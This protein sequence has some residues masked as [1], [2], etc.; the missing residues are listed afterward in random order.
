MCAVSVIPIRPSDTR[1]SQDSRHIDDP[2][3]LESLAQN[4]EEFFRFDGSPDARQLRVPFR[5]SEAIKKARRTPSLWRGIGVMATRI[6]G[7]GVDIVPRFPGATMTPE[8]ES[9][10]DLVELFIELS[11]ANCGGYTELRRLK[12]LDFYT[13]GNGAWRL[14]RNR[15]GAVAS[16]EHLPTISFRLYAPE[17]HVVR[18][19]IFLPRAGKVI[20]VER[21]RLFYTAR[22]YQ[23]G[24][25]RWYKQLGHPR[26]LRSTDGVQ[27][28]TGGGDFRDLEAQEF[29]LWRHLRPGEHHY[30]VPPWW[31]LDDETEAEAGVG[32]VLR[33][34]TKNGLM[35][36]LLVLLSNGEWTPATRAEIDRHLTEHSRGIERAFNVILG[37]AEAREVISD[38]DAA[39]QGANTVNV[40]DLSSKFSLDTMVSQMGAL[41]AHNRAYAFGIHPISMGLSSDYTRA[42][43]GA[44]K[45]MDEESIFIPARLTDDRTVNSRILPAMGVTHWVVRTR[46]APTQEAAEQAGAAAPFLAQGVLTLNQMLEWVGSIRGVQYEPIEE[47]WADVPVAALN[48]VMSGRQT[49]EDAQQDEGAVQRSAALGDAFRQRVTR[50]A[51]RFLDRLASTVED[52]DPG[53]LDR[54]AE[55]A[56]DVMRSAGLTPPG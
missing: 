24:V 8:Q 34:W 38:D 54:V 3:Q 12:D 32:R 45:A 41:A 51:D 2:V 16:A 26:P 21:P 6:G 44:A 47:E 28:K 40:V 35:S 11:G 53:F 49:P 52:S 42:T 37:E 20:E 46:N 39:K 30:G 36:T 13:V 22:A 29:L 56:A 14:P 1:R 43:A 4:L 19:P 15:G 18:D 48:A 10:R 33:N 23:D 7:F 50:S 5:F 27:G 25:T 55:R 17:E 9:Q 31:A